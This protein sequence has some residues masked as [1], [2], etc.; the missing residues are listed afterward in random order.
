MGHN[1]KNMPMQY[2]V[3]VQRFFQLETMKM[4]LEFV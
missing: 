4:S 3:H 2:N 1:D